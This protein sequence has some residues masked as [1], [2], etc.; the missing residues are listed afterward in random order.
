MVAYASAAR[1]ALSRLD[2]NIPRYDR[3][4]QRMYRRGIVSP[5]NIARWLS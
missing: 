1:M 5:N 4:R 2:G 3:A